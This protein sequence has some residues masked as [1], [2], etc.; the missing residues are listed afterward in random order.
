MK[1]P[2]D[3]SNSPLHSE[4]LRRASPLAFLHQ[5]PSASLLLKGKLS[6]KF[7][8]HPAKVHLVPGD[9]SVH[10]SMDGWGVALSPA[11]FSAGE[12]SFEVVPH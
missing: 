9:G 1:R 7:G 4:T 12:E 6:M 5:N 8:S 2:R 10:G 3:K 11:T